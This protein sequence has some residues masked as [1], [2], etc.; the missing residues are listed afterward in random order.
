MS[1]SLSRTEIPEV[2]ELRA[3]D[4]PLTS[5]AAADAEN[6]VS[7]RDTED[8][9]NAR[10]AQNVEG[11]QDTDS[12][13][14][15]ES[16]Q[17]VRGRAS[18]GVGEPAAGSGVVD[19]VKALMLR[20]KELCERAVDP[21]EIAAELEAQGV[22]D[23][24]AS[25][26][27]HRDVFSLAEEMYARVPRGSEPAHSPAHSASARMDSADGTDGSPVGRSRPSSAPFPAAHC[28]ASRSSGSFGARLGRFLL[29]LL[30]GAF[31]VLAV[32]GARLTHG[33]LRLGVVAAGILAVTLALRAAL[34]RGPLHATRPTTASPAWTC[35]LLL[36]ALV[37][38]GLLREAIAGGPDEPWPVS[39]APV[40]A[41]TLSFA[42]ATWCALLFTAAAHRRL[43]AS[44]GLAEFTASVWPLL[45]GT[46]ALYLGAL[47]T[48]LGLTA[49][50]LGE[51]PAYATAGGLG[52]LLLL[53]RLLS[54]HGH[55]RAPAVALALAGAAEVIALA[56]VFAARLPG[57]AAV[58]VP[59]TDAVRT[60]GAGAIP[61]AICSAAAL[62]L[63]VHATRSLTRA[64]AH[65]PSGG[66]P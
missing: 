53:A 12:T 50:T 23:R 31:C 2:G 63:L 32:A 64:S 65:A 41:L 37:G 33:Q 38:D 19:P 1:G 20:H 34:R 5:A 58:A 47:A 60:W 35:W 3:A 54:A 56:A 49:R 7:V 61:A 28:V 43:T 45:L 46:F 36:Y 62:V 30:P 25:R 22:T 16:G 51:D 6:T 15:A 66:I 4:M 44:R 40:V 48:L 18:A 13:Q 8:A 26:F 17:G 42:P 59:V 57:C 27:R 11:A 24:T 29:P 21:L 14:G 55:T 10:G 9:Q 39:V 52:A